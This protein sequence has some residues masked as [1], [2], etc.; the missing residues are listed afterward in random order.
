[1]VRN[2]DIP[3]K[4]YM[5]PRF[6]QL[7]INAQVGLVRDSLGWI[8]HYLMGCWCHKQVHDDVADDIVDT[9]D[10]PTPPLPATTLPPQQELIPSSS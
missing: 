4:F 8:L 3:S 1:L 6:L 10:K 5:Y 9:D 2:V 7:M